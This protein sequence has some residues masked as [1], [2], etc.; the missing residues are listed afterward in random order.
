MKYVFQGDA[1]DSLGV[2][3]AAE[4][5][6]AGGLLEEMPVDAEDAVDAFE[7]IGVEIERVVGAN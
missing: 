1:L 6:F 4:L 5:A 2:M 3:F 7:A